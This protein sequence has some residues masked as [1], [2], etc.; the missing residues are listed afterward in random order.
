M[1]LFEIQW[2]Y[3]VLLWELLTRGEKPYA[4]VDSEYMV[5]YLENNHRLEKPP[6]ASEFM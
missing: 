2:S 4:D 3:G 1:C 6:A 5:Q